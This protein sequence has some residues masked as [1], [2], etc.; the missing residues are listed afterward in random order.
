MAKN[1]RIQIS[2]LCAGYF[3]PMC[4]DYGL[5]HLE[6]VC[7]SG[8]SEDLDRTDQIALKI[9]MQIKKTAPQEI[10]QQMQD[11]ITWIKEA[12]QNKLVVGSQAR[13]LYADA[14][15][16]AAIAAALIVQ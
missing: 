1:G 8:N 10:Q 6:W 15:G 2:F 12:K 16:R 4:F 7:T 11:N 14:E 9:M 3:G 5:A 13:I